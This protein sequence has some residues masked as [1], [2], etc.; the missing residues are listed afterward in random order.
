MLNGVAWINSG[1]SDKFLV[2]ASEAALTDFTIAQMQALKIYAKNETKYPCQAF[3]LEKKKNTMVLGEA[4]AVLCLE[5]GVI[6]HAIAKVIGIGYATEILEHNI[7]I[8]TEATCF[9][10][11][12]RM[13]LGENSTDDIDAIVMHAPGTI[14]GDL[15]EV[16][17]IERVFGN[18]TP[19]LTTNKWKLGHTFATS[20]IL[21]VELAI[22]MLQ[23]QQGISVPFT[24]K[25]NQPSQ[26]HK[27]LINAVGFGGNAVSILLSK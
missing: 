21:S 18:N 26:L 19:F 2:G 13:A 23:H 15:S 12:M 17:A 20:G 5:E 8:S 6:D 24:P 16:K 22:L 4:A 7:S 9:Q 25:Q 3:N 11:S 1:M 27:I 10:K 14:K